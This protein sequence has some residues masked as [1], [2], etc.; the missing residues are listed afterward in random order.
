VTLVTGTMFAPVLE[1]LSPRLGAL[2]IDSRVLAV[3]NRFLGGNIA[4]TGLLTGADLI[5]AITADEGPGPYFVPDV[6]AN[7][8]GLLLDDVP[9]DDL[10][11]RTGAD[12][13]LVA[14]DGEGFVAGLG[15]EAA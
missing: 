1:G 2:G 13:A 6:V 12:V 14:S 8:D 7:A 11:A 4:V 15:G 5:A 10:A 3:R 9:A